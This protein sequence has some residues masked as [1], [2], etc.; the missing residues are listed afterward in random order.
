MVYLHSPGGRLVAPQQGPTVPHPVVT[1][2]SK[3]F[4]ERNALLFGA[5]ARP[6]RRS[7]M[8]LADDGSRRV[9]RM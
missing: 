8:R 9:V 1:V 7:A 2:T 6:R 3:A 5:V 4:F